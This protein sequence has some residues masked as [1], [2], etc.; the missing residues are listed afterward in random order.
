MYRFCCWLFNT[1]ITMMLLGVGGYFLWNY[2]GRPSSNEIIDGLEDLWHNRTDHWDDFTDVLDG[3]GD[4]DFGDLMGG[5]PH[6]S[7]NSTN[8]WKTSGSGGLELTLVDALDTTWTEEYEV[9]V[10]DWENGTPDSLTL[11][12]EKAAAP[13][14]ECAEHI[15]GKMKVCN[16][17]FGETGWLGLNE[18]YTNTRSGTIISSLAKMNEF[19]LRNADHA[20]RQY[21][22]CHELGHGFGLPHTDESFT[23]PSLGN[24]LD[25]THTP[26]D[27]M[28]P[29]ETNYN[30]LAELY[31]TVN[32]RRMLSLRQQTVDTITNSRKLSE[33]RQLAHLELTGISHWREL[34]EEKGSWSILDEHK[35][36]VSLERRLNNDDDYVL[37]VHMLLA[38]SS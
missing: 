18:I 32:D 34:V 7:N 3:L 25:Y 26:A 15:D 35:K 16:G 10:L 17:N 27:N 19:Y 28:H 22:M 24:C 6:L 8:S 11:S 20:E 30:R 37:Q 9:A 14:F 2:M 38:N 33:E 12:T 13:D 29:D 4:F 31:G 23:N 1:M 36:G 21:T 5:E